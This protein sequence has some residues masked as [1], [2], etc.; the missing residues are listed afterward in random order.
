MTVVT[1]SS[2]Y[3]FPDWPKP[4][5]GEPA[6]FAV[7]AADNLRE[8]KSMAA[9]ELMPVI[10][11]RRVH[12]EV[13]FMDCLLRLL[14]HDGGD[15]VNFHQRL[16]RQCGDS[17]RGA[18]RAAV[19]EVSLEYLV[20]T[21][22]LVNLAQE[23]S[24]L[25][26]AVHRSAARCHQGFYVFHH[27]LRV[28]FDVEWKFALGIVRMCAL[29]GNVD[30]AV[31]DDERGDES[32]SGGLA[33]VVQLLNG[34]RSLGGGRSGVAEQAGNACPGQKRSKFS[35]ESSASAGCKHGV[36]LKMISIY[37]RKQK[38]SLPAAMATY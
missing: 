22:V 15:A 2:S 38:T 31:V 24:E 35:G 28:S 18:G 1:P 4:L 27:F 16:A 11:L 33:L 36:L 10:K 20:H 3:T 25:K 14:A 8:P 30:G 37:R 23:D 21:V 13:M 26:D 6:A 29:A 19:R 7:G 32:R 5:M 12:F 9:S 34:A 17:D